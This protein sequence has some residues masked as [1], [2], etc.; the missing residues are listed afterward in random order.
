[1]GLEH[2]QSQ[3]NTAPVSLELCGLPTAAC[4]ACGSTWLVTAISLDP[5]TYDIAAWKLEGA[6]CYDCNST[7]TL[8]CPPDH[9][10]FLP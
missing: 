2:E 1:M 7:V 3:G 6:R 4:P 5:Q 9:P 10:D 8:A